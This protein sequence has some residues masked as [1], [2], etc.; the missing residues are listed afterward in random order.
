MTRNFNKQRRENERPYSRSSSSGRYGDGRSPRPARPRL[1]RDTV[2]RA[3]ENGARQNHADY[4]TRGNNT[5]QPP[6]DNRR[7]SQ[8]SDQSSA[9]NSRNN[10]KPYG[11]QDNYRH[12]ERT[13]HGTYEP[14]ARSFESGMRNFNQQRYSENEHRGYSD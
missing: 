5:S 10:R 1:N 6:R 11:S 2:D 7:R 8:F 3:W 9:Q 13:S 4:R 12:R 14:R